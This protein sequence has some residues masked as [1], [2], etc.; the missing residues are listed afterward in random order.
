MKGTCQHCGYKTEVETQFD[1]WLGYDRTLC[2]ICRTTE[3][4]FQC[5]RPEIKM[6]R[7]VCYLANLILERLDRLEKKL[8]KKS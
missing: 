5:D 3:L 4:Q 8:E 2:K 7:T 6:R 1:S